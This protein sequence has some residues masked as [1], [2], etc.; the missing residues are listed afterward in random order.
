MDNELLWSILAEHK[1]H[2]VQIRAYGNPVQDI[3]L[4]CDDCN[5]VILDSE[6]Y[7]ISERTDL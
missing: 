3:C 2:N 6:V 5:E 1:N 7:T 4:E